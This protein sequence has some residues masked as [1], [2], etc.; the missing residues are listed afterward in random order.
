MV[1]RP[2]L[3]GG[4]HVKGLWALTVLVQPLNIGTLCRSHDQ[5][6]FLS[7]F[8]PS[9]FNK[10]VS[11]SSIFETR[12]LSDESN[13]LDFGTSVWSDEDDMAGSGSGAGD[14]ARPLDLGGFGIRLAF[15]CLGFIG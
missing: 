14:L 4:D 3:D 5:L 7:L 2:G 9:H 11:S 10:S 15:F 8:M 13:V 12:Y 6:F 1:Q